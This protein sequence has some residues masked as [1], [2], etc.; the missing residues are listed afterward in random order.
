MTQED[1]NFFKMMFVLYFMVIPSLIGAWASFALYK[2][3][4]ESKGK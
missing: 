4:R 3:Y 1:L 2:S